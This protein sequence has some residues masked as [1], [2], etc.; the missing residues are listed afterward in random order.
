MFQFQ[1]KE[2]DQQCLF[3]QK[4]IFSEIQVSINL[5]GKSNQ[6]LEL[7][8]VEEGS[9]ADKLGEYKQYLFNFCDET[10]TITAA[11][12]F[13]CYES[14]I[15]TFVNASIKNEELFK[16]QLFFSAKHA[17]T[18]TINK[19]ME[20]YEIMANYQHKDWWTRPFF[21]KNI[22]ELPER[23]QSLLLKNEQNYY[24]F[25]P[26]CDEIS[27]TDLAGTEKGVQ[28]SIS[29]FHGGYDHLSTFA[30][31]LGTAMNPF[32]LVNENV[33]A[34]LTVTGQSTLPREEKN[35]PEILDYLGWC[36][37]D[38]FYHAVNEEGILTKAEEIK[39]KQLPVKWMMIDDGW[40]EIDGK[41]LQS[42]NADRDKFPNGLSNTVSSLKNNYGINWVGV[43][44][45]LAGYWEGIAP[46]SPIAKSLDKHLY[47]TKNGSL[48]PSPKAEEGFGFWHSWHSKLKK[49]GIDFVK[50]DS[51]SALSNF[52]GNHKSVGEAASGAHTALEASCSM[53]FDNT[54][55]NCMGMAAENI[56][57]RP[58]SAV[59]RNSDDFVPQENNSFKEHALQ[60]AYNSL[61]HGAFYW[62]D[63][64]MYWTHNHDDMQNMVL[65]VVS[66]G[67]IYFSDA[68]DQT[69]PDKIW[70]LVY[71]DG[72]IIRCDQP[73]VPTEDCLFID[74]ITTRIPLKIW[75]TCKG[76]GVVAAFHISE[77]NESV[78]GSIGAND[79]PALNGETFVIFDV[80]TKKHWKVNKDER[81]SIE[82]AENGVSLYVIIPIQDS[83]TPIGLLNKLIC[84][85][86]IENVWST[87]KDM[88]VILKEGGVFALLSENPL[89][90]ASVNGKE[91]QVQKDSANKQLYTID[92]NDLQGEVLVEIAKAD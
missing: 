51:Q 71:K 53:H 3:D 39:Q 29:P 88:K 62:G 7:E 9:G 26:V 69:N 63:W 92:C 35:Y 73:G 58:Y 89:L 52:M 8:K 12:T 82:L 72:K 91:V 45:T 70:P 65:R 80:M 24:H 68:V 50:V 46:E 33:K 21:T 17:V 20:D 49:D 43:W 85:D 11:L 18:I 40:S 38:A 83:I 76:A 27:R 67:P 23:T 59:S 77:G 78:H 61:Y 19:L 54:V 86:G 32:D 47:K 79:I 66:G 36:S 1:Q 4:R 56:W 14:F 25:L 30:F 84:N 48:I 74:P 28:I 2:D 57:H 34:A 90:K 81:I 16:K 44:H 55:I 6:S 22:Q 10:E 37:W 75:N 60:N 87:G 15:T 13:N 5:E 41:K 42:F 64:D 31:I